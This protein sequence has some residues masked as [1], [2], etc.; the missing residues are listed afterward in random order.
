MWYIKISIIF[1]FKNSVFASCVRLCNK[2]RAV[3]NTL[4][5]T[6]EIAKWL[7]ACCALCGLPA[8][9]PPPP[10][11][12]GRTS[13]LAATFFFSF[14]FCEVRRNTWGKAKQNAMRKTRKPSKPK[15]CQKGCENRH[16]NSL[17]ILLACCCLIFIFI[18]FFVCLPIAI[19]F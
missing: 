19:G 4:T 9:L 17:V 16:L 6:I 7:F 8:R 5:C 2:S 18:L 15:Q 10:P 14:A 1:D 12:L 3:F 13:K 11:P